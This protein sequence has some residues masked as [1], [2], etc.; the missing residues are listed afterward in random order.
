[1]A[2]GGGTG[3]V[4]TEYEQL[5]AKVME[6]NGDPSKSALIHALLQTK[7]NWKIFRLSVE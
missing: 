3:N 2:A 1:M 4:G 6:A 5:I 7:I